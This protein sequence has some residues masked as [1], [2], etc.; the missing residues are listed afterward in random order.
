M[1][2]ADTPCRR[3][4]PKYADDDQPGRYSASA[5]ALLMKPLYLARS[6]RPEISFAIG[7]LA[8]RITKWTRR[9]DRECDRLYAYLNS[10]VSFKLTG[11]IKVGCADALFI[12]DFPDAD[13]AGDAETARSTSGMWIELCDGSGGSFPLE[14]SSKL[15]TVV[16]HSTPEAELVSMSRSMREYALPLQ[17]MWS[18]LLNRP[19]DLEV[20][21]DNMS[22]IEIVNKGYSSR[23]AHL[24]RTHRISVAW[25]AEQ[26]A[27]P[28]V[29]LTHCPTAEQKADSFTKA[30]D[31]IKHAEALQSLGIHALTALHLPNSIQVPLHLA[32]LACACAT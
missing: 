22:T 26:A 9:D 12:R 32:I 31:K 4:A 8:R 18:A 1:E 28:D 6:A 17:E 16:S 3:D 27:K 29:K 5:P 13:L 20:L 11:T 14:W 23:L 2:K 19:I 24:P 21:E 30:L 10:T 7:R 15:Q 25:T